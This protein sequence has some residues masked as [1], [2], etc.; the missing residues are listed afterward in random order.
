M[1]DYVILTDATADFTEN[2]LQDFPFLDSI[3]MPVTIGD[4]EYLY[5]GRENE[6]SCETFYQLQRNGNFAQT[7][8]ISPVV[9]QKYFEKYLSQGLDV[10]YLGFSSGMSGTYQSALLSMRDLQ[11]KY[12]ERKIACIDTLNGSTSLGFLVHEAVQKKQEGFDFDAL[13]AWVE[14]HK[15]NVCAYFVVDVL[16]HLVHGGRISQGAAIVGSTLHIKP[17][18]R[19]DEAGKLE[20]I[21][22][23]RGVKRAMHMVI[24][25]LEEK[26]DPSMN[27][28]MLICH[29]DDIEKA[30]ELQALVLEVIPDAQIDISNVGPV[31]GAHTGPG[32][33]SL[34]Y[35]GTNR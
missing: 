3:P 30:H 21:A 31:I 28:Y 2:L 8:Q 29:A 32:M 15:L 23:P 20:V 18:M 33:V 25:K 22:K 27:N 10:V 24:E 12:P 16:D 13:V 26:K 34:C 11:N 7:S 5:G 9:F 17:F 1:P 19:I 6:L 35:W 14:E 4:K